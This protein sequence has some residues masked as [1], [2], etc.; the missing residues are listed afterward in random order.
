MG[1]EIDLLV[2]HPKT[3]REV[4]ERGAENTEEERAIARQ[5]GRESLTSLRKVIPL[6]I[7]TMKKGGVHG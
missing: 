1:R 4:K 2:D 6:G 7:G 3:K 5:F